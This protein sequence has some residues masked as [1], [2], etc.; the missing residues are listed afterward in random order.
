ME[1]N[2]E[3]KECCREISEEEYK[4]YS[5][6]CKKCYNEKNNTEEESPSSLNSY[7]KISIFMFICTMIAGIIC[8][9]IYTYDTY[10]KFNI[11]IMFAIWICGFVIFF[12]FYMLST[13]IQELRNIQNK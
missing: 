13:I 8:G 10:D 12:L 11:A 3:C 9:S 4:E 1:K 5:G 6:Y 2:Y 7:H